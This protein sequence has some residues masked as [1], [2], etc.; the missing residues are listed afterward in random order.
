MPMARI[1]KPHL[2]PTFSWMYSTTVKSSSMA[3]PM[4]K[5]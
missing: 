3:R 2:H 4:V 1:P 5:K